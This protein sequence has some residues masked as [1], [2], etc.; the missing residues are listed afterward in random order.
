V[1]QAEGRGHRDG[2]APREAVRGGPGVMD[3]FPVA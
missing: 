3:L 1:E 2:E